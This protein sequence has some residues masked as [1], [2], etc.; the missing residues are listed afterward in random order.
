MATL[1]KLYKHKKSG[2]MVQVIHIG[3][4]QT[5]EP[6]E[7]LKDMEPMVIYYHNFN[8]WVRSEKEFDDGR[9]EL[10]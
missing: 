10:C 6:T 7:I 3:K 9:F 8:I 2:H 5:A 1:G 4:L